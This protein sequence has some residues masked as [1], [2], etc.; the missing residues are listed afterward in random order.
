MITYS[1]CCLCAPASLRHGPQINSTTL[2]KFPWTDALRDRRSMIIT[3]NDTGNAPALMPGTRP[4][5]SPAIIRKRV[6]CTPRHEASWSTRRAEGCRG[7]LL[8]KECKERAGGGTGPPTH[9]ERRR[10]T[11]AIGDSQKVPT[12]R[13]HTS[14]VIRG[15]V[16]A[17]AKRARSGSY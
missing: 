4:H 9:S 6:K 1:T 16:K 3:K 10:G 11:R 13:I 5:Y 15:N 8:T 14:A 7:R 17:E 2:S 12:L